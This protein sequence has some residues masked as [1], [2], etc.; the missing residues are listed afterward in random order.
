MAVFRSVFISAAFGGI[1]IVG[2]DSPY[3]QD[4]LS[5]YWPYNRDT[6]PRLYYC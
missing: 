3:S 4:G 2:I 1:Y 5:G 6:Y